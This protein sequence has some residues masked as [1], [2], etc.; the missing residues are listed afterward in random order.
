MERLVHTNPGRTILLL[1][2][3]VSVLTLICPAQQTQ[4][5]KPSVVSSLSE[6]RSDDA[7]ER[8]EAYEQL[9]SDPSAIHSPKVQ[10]ALLDLLD[11]EEHVIE[12][13]LRGSH[14]QVGVSDKYGEGYGE[15]VAE[16]AD[17]VNSFADWNDPH[18]AC[19]LV[20]ESYNPDSRFAAEIAS[21]WKTAIPCLVKMYG[22]DVGLTRGQAAPVLVRALTYSRDGLDP[23]TL[24]AVR[25]IIVRAL[26]D[27]HEAVRG[28]TVEALGSFGG[29]DMIP[30]LKAV[31]ETDPSP[32]VQG[33]SIRKSASQAIAAIQKRGGGQ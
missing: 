23:A 9:R 6:L 10:T 11:R 30:T 21:H 18:Q 16:L 22:S 14:E 32:E 29:E 3:Q 20:H 8:A 25:G 33:H 27:P 5:S 28:N 13:T 15:Y 31:A 19:I 24:Q 4:V 1:V 2:A 7:G 17:T 12:S 26:H